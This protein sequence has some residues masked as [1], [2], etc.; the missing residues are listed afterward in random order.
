[1]QNDEIK[2][3][4]RNEYGH[5][6]T[7]KNRYDML[8]QKMDVI[9]KYCKWEPSK[10]FCNIVNGKPTNV[11]VE[12]KD[13][14]K[15]ELGLD[16]CSDKTAYLEW[17]IEKVLQ[18]KE[19]IKYVHKFDTDVIPDIR[20]SER[21]QRI[22]LARCCSTN[23]KHLQDIRMN[24]LDIDYL[25][26]VWNFKKNMD[27]IEEPEY[28]NDTIVK[29]ACVL[30]NAFGVM[31]YD[32][33]IQQDSLDEYIYFY[34]EVE[35]ETIVTMVNVEGYEKKSKMHKKVWV[36]TNKIYED[37]EEFI[38]VEHEVI[39]QKFRDYLIK[40]FTER[41]EAFLTYINAEYKPHFGMS[42]IPKDEE[43]VQILESYKNRWYKC[44]DQ[45]KAGFPE[46]ELEAENVSK[47]LLDSDV[48][49]NV[50]KLCEFFFEH[51]KEVVDQYFCI[52][53]FEEESEIDDEYNNVIT[54]NY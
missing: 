33:L 32:S 6:L 42:F 50:M 35:I 44:Q 22:Q 49:R 10:V 1:L 25:K 51:K 30:F 37:S 24:K 45:V 7:S 19:T 26:N 39:R 5:E 15:K 53:D 34:K 54:I 17:C 41:K 52:C 11:F 9:D 2:E 36:K 43:D 38:Y 12:P 31:S 47:L 4:I 23:Y 28:L 14:Y 29:Y 3:I 16:Y 27:Y 18:F 20:R 48:F 21:E 46:I 8:I 13:I 40:F